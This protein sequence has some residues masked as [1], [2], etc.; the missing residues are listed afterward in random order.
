ME[1]SEISY[2]L[3]NNSHTGIL[4]NKLLHTLQFHV[5]AYSLYAPSKSVP[6][7]GSNSNEVGAFLNYYDKGVVYVARILILIHKTTEVKHN[8]TH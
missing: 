2:D 6:G 4:L 8:V 7:Y 1:R 5:E 3:K